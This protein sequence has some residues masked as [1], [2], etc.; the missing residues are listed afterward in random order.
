MS[1]C[2]GD[3]CITCS[4]TAVQVTVVVAMAKVAPEAG[5]QAMAAATA[6]PCRLVAVGAV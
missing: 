4:D 2:S 3:V 1:E 5:V 6:V